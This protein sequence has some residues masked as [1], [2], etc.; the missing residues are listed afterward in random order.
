MAD[1]ETGCV[2]GSR[3]WGRGPLPQRTHTHADVLE[4]W[5]VVGSGLVPRGGGRACFVYGAPQLGAKRAPRPHRCRSPRR[6]G[7]WGRW[8]DAHG[9]RRVSPL[10]V[11]R[12][13]A[14]LRLHATGTETNRRSARCGPGQV[15]TLEN[16]SSA[17]RLCGNREVA[18]EGPGSECSRKLRRLPGL[19]FLICKVGCGDRVGQWFG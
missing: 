8:R 7:V 12:P 4:W 17:F 14:C 15:S 16:P 1:G 6:P 2:R 19:G 9:R 3:G 18:V 10:G 5:W 11:L 13:S